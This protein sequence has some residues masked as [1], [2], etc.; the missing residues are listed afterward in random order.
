[1]PHAY[2]Y[3]CACTHT[4]IHLKIKNKTPSNFKTHGSTHSTPLDSYD[5]FLQMR[6]YQTHPV[7]YFTNYSE[8]HLSLKRL[9]KSNSK[10]SS[11]RTIVCLPHFTHTLLLWGTGEFW[12][13][14]IVMA[15]IHTYLHHSPQTHSPEQITPKLGFLD[16]RRTR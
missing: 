11:G 7:L 1:M 12:C 14:I 5:S 13:S 16:Q 9:T 8:A 4:E 10:D 2:I 15:C 3:V 6:A